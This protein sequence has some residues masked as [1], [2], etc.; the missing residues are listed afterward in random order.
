MSGNSLKEKYDRDGF[1]VVERAFTADALDAVRARTDE[2]IAN[3]SLAP[4]GAHVGR[5]SDTRGDKLKP[6]PAN[7][8]VRKIERMVAGD[9]TFQ[10][11]ARNEK[12]LEM[13][14]TLIGP[15]V[16]VFRDQMLLKPPGGQDKPPHQD[17]SYFRVKP[18]SGLVTAWIALD[19]ATLENG[20][21][22]YVPGS[23]RHGLFEMEQ[24]PERP[25]HHVPKV[26]HLNLTAE[27]ACPVPA[28][29]VIFH[30]GLTL[31]R[32]GVNNTNTWRKALI[33]HF[34]T[35]EARSEIGKLNEEVS[36]VID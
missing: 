17:Q 9:G 11:F 25:V 12:L 26:S 6:A 19:D 14:R 10:A 21:M 35:A 36:L 1:L 7:D 28:G 20:C 18:E 27:V 13:V 3:P 34:A 15:R 2:I 22:R 24:D 33:L 23:H 32:S 30:H 5:E 16:K 31:H 4:A 8:P 29:S